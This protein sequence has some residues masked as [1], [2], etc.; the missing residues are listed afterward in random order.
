MFKCPAKKGYFTSKI[1]LETGIAALAAEENEE[2][3]EEKE[4]KEKE[5]K[6]KEKKEKEKKNKEEEKEEKEEEKKE[7][8]KEIEEKEKEKGKDKNDCGNE[9][10]FHEKKEEKEGVNIVVTEN[11]SKVPAVDRL[12]WGSFEDEVERC[13]K[14]ENLTELI[15]LLE[16]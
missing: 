10:I 3:G 4:K 7:R 6:E 15:L 2:D 5:K 11:R 12:L 9:K 1:L 8:E 13:L 16:K 14:A